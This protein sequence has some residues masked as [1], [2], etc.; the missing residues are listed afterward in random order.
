[1]TNGDVFEIIGSGPLSSRLKLFPLR[2]ASHVNRIRKQRIS[3]LLPHGVSQEGTRHIGIP[4]LRF[5]NVLREDLKDFDIE[6]EYR[7]S[8]L[9]VFICRNNISK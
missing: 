2:W 8:R 6:P 9:M 7:T 3:R 4:K 1:M 5:E